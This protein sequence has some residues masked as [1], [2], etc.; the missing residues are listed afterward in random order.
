VE[1]FLKKKENADGL[2]NREIRKKRARVKL[3]LRAGGGE[4][5]PHIYK[6]EI[7]LPQ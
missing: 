1:E 4:S 6:G 3:K 5:D 2:E 7:E